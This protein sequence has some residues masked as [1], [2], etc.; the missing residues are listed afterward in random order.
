MMSISVLVATLVALNVVPGVQTQSIRDKTNDNERVYLNP[1]QEHRLFAK[2]NAT[3]SEKQ[4]VTGY[5]LS[6]GWPSREVDGWTLSLSVF[7]DKPYDEKRHLTATQFNYTSPTQS[8][9]STDNQRANGWGLCGY[10]AWVEYD[11]NAEVDSG[12][13]G[14]ISDQCREALQ[15]KAVEKGELCLPG[16]MLPDECDDELRGD[17]D[18]N[19][20]LQLSVSNA[21]SVSQTLSGALHEPGDFEYYDKMVTRVFVTA[22]GFYEWAIKDGKNGINEDGEKIPGFLSCARADELEEGSRSV[23]EAVKAIE[24]EGSSGRIGAPMVLVALAAA[25]AVMGL[26]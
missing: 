7:G 12:C 16:G 26:V 19:R 14:V 10:F 18:K 8:G 20:L 9:N 17:D 15:N 24:E 4:N 1:N 13:K 25:V 11:T 2:A 3:L 22:I 21:M 23:E 5:D 6:R